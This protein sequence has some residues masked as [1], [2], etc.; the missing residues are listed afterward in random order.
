MWIIDLFAGIAISAI[1][2]LLAQSE[3]ISKEDKLVRQKLNNLSRTEVDNLFCTQAS[4]P[5]YLNPLHFC[6]SYCP[7]TRQEHAVAFMQKLS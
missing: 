5:A 3:K 6:S 7:L 2:I 4:N 1:I